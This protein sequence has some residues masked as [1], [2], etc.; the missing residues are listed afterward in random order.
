ML[1]R[2]KTLVVTGGN[3][4]IDEAIVRA[5]AAEGASETHEIVAAIQQLGGHARRHHAGER[6]TVSS[7]AR[8]AGPRAVR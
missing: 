4:G 7:G 2:G 6:G 1:L 5:A 8:L 3:G